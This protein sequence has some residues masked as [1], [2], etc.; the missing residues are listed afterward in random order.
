M[1]NALLTTSLVKKYWMAGTGLFL[2]IFLIGHLAGNLQLLIPEA[3]GA[4]DQF[5]A[6]A[7]FMTHN[8]VVKILSWITYVSILIHAIDGIILVFQNRAARPTKYIKNNTSGNSTWSSRNMG[9]L[10]TI[11]LAFIVIHMSNF[12]YTMHWGPIE[13]YTL[14]DQ[15]VKDLYT[16]VI[17]FFADPSMGLVFTTFYVISMIA[18]A[19]HLY[20]GFQSAFQSFGLNHPEWNTIIKR[21]GYGFAI[22]IPLLFAIIP[23][24]IHFKLL[25]Q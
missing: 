17:K 13:T 25:T 2:C 9:L 24:A 21:T 5:N 3:D 16:V 12:W 18:I 14:D 20:H 23:I 8:P 19:F 11:I 1:A 22:L 10:G 6:Y 4:R 7:Y 15:P